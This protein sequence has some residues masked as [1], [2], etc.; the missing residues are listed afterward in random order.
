MSLAARLLNIF[1]IP[2][3]VF[4][5]VKIGPVSAGNW[6]APALLLLAVSW[7]GAWLIFSQESVKQK[8][9]EITDQAIQKQ[10][11]KGKLPK[12]QADRP[13]QIAEMAVK[14]APFVAPL[15][16]AFITPFT[17]GFIFWLLGT[18]VL[19][20]NF[21]Y[22]K[23]VEV[24]GLA[25][26]IMVLEAVVKILLIVGLGNP[27]ASPGPVLLVKEFDP[28][29]PIHSLLALA[30]VMTFWLLTIRAI[31]LARLAGTTWG[32]AGVWVFAIWLVYTGVPLGLGLAMRAL[33]PH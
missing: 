23:A 17:W 26:T 32:K 27:F 25:N 28:Q 14:I 31:G 7:V 4:N 24:A 29:N 19:H 5:E 2:S 6:L 15:F 20:G 33:V 16:I 13:R 30:N 11:E 18:K 22:M 12:E 9:S 1:A 3:E 10:I 21:P 8:M